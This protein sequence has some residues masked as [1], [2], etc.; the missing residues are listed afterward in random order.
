MPIIP[1]FIALGLILVGVPVLGLLIGIGLALG[2]RLV[3]QDHQQ[4]AAVS[5]TE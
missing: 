1:W 5:E 4:Q 2:L 3:M